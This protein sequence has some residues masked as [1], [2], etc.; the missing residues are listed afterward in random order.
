MRTAATARM[1]TLLREFNENQIY[2][3][4]F[5]TWG[6]GFFTKLRNIRVR[7]AKT[8][9]LLALCAAAITFVKTEERL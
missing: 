3:R 7:V 8:K 1:Y 5:T 2:S 9:V 4:N 6:L